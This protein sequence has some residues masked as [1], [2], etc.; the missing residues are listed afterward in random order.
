MTKIEKIVN[1]K[2]DHFFLLGCHSLTGF[3]PIVRR[4]LCL[5]NFAQYPNKKR[6]P[7]VYNSEVVGF[8]NLQKAL[9]KF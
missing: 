5:V 6:F 7:F 4:G 3:P 9:E 1:Q 8:N 2:N